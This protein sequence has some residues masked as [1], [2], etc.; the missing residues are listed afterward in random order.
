MKRLLFCSALAMA[1]VSCSDNVTN[2]TTTTDSS[3]MIQ[4]GSTDPNIDGSGTGGSMSD[5]TMGSSN[6]GSSMGSDSATR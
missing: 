6:M 3:T 5:T 1:I 2:S 4:G